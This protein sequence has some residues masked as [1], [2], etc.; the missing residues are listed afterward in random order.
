M[1][2]Q[3]RPSAGVID[4]RKG[5]AETENVYQAH[6]TLNT[7]IDEVKAVLGSRRNHRLV[8]RDD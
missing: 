7:R 3:S 4:L 5:W 8:Y 1:L 2:Y 6:E